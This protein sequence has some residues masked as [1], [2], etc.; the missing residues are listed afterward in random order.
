M[1]HCGTISTKQQ[2]IFEKKA[3]REAFIELN[4]NKN[5]HRVHASKK[6][7]CRQ[8]EKKMIFNLKTL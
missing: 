8:R 2:V 7:Y 5:N 4:I 3:N 6:S 1:I